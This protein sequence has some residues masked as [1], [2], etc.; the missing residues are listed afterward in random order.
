IMV[1]Y[2]NGQDFPAPDGWECLVEPAVEAVPLTP[3]SDWDISWEVA[4]AVRADQCCTRCQAQPQA[5]EEWLRGWGSKHPTSDPEERSLLCPTCQAELHRWKES[6]LQ[7]R[8]A[9]EQACK[10]A[11]KAKQK[12]QVGPAPVA[13]PTETDVAEY[14]Q[15]WDVYF[16]TGAVATVKKTAARITSAGVLIVA[17]ARLDRGNPATVE[18]RR[19]IIESRIKQL[20]KAA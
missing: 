6:L 1:A 19:K 16:E 7:E 8:L 11:V 17:L 12:A 10:A 15:T 18:E 20:Q 5:G 4:R 3:I 13:E 2:Q 9:E 14:E